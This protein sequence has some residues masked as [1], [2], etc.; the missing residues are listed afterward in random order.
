MLTQMSHSNGSSHGDGFP[1][2]DCRMASGGA[3]AFAMFQ[4][5]ADVGAAAATGGTA[6]L[7]VMSLTPGWL[8][9]HDAEPVLEPARP[10]GPSP[11]ASVVASAREVEI[12]RRRYPATTALSA[13][14]AAA[15]HA[16]TSGIRCRSR[17][18]AKSP[19]ERHTK[20]GVEHGEKRRRAGRGQ[21][22]GRR[23]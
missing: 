19:G 18:A 7:A 11:L 14:R 8:G 15:A 4:V 17:T 20:A 6:D 10:P 23:G 5:R 1:S 21:H 13:L 9:P 22:D 2:S 16:R 12:S 3:F